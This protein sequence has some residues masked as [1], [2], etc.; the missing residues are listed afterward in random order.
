[1][2][3]SEVTQRQYRNVIKQSVVFQGRRFA[4][5][6]QE[7]PRCSDVPQRAVREREPSAVLPDTSGETV[8]WADGGSVRGIGWQRKWSG[9]AANPASGMRTVN[10]GQT[11]W[12]E[13]RGTAGNAG[14]NDARRRRRRRTEEEVRIQ[15][16][17]CEW[18][19]DWYLGIREALPSTDP[20]G[21]ATRR[22]PGVPWRRVEQ[23][24]GG[25]A[26][27]SATTSRPR[28]ATTSSVFGQ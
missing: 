28:L 2:A 11:Q 14:G 27:R 3:E 21:P 23:H 19:V 1:M 5:G 10:A 22:V 24:R 17:T 8:G 6:V 25:R 13:W 12:M 15:A 9:N 26:L 20:V 18:G 16:G 4:S 7:L